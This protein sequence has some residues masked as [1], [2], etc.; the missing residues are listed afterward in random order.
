MCRRQHLLAFGLVA[1]TWGLAM[2]GPLSVAIVPIALFL[3]FFACT[4]RNA[5]PVVA[6]LVSPLGIAF[7]IGASRWF[8]ER[9]GLVGS[10]L[11]SAAAFNLDRDTRLWHNIG[12]CVVSGNEWVF[13]M[14]HN[15]GLR[16]MRLIAGAP[17]TY[18][19]TYPSESEALALTGKAPTTPAKTFFDGV[20]L[21]DDGELKIGAKVAEL[22]VRDL[23]QDEW[24]AEEILA[25]GHVTASVVNQECLI[26]RVTSEGE[27]F[28]ETKRDGAMLFD[29]KTMLPFA[30]YSFQGTLPRIPRY[31]L[32]D[33]GYGRVAQ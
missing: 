33:Q 15:A 22:I 4:R 21:V 5:L 6:L 9:P 1:A 29:F 12:G 16:L 7:L 24:D 11:P 17:A 30:R 19:G 13:E 20:L 28:R 27:Y 2:I 10:G 3:V 25:K 23:G 32:R 8:S 26:V 31:V 14:P 18:R